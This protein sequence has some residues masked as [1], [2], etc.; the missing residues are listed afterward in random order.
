M[1]HKRDR[2]L[3]NSQIHKIR[4]RNAIKRFKNIIY[5]IRQGYALSTLR[6]CMGVFVVVLFFSYLFSLASPTK[7]V[8]KT[9]LQ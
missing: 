3:E 5:D 4:N 1:Q 7:I 6:M 9:V 8:F 2:Q